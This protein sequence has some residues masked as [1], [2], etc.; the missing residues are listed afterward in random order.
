MVE[1]WKGN[2]IIA[3]QDQALGTN[4]VK[5]HAKLCHNS[6]DGDDSDTD[7]DNDCDDQDYDHED[8]DANNKRLW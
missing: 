5:H 6:N 7:Y 3:L 1:T 8:V 4:V 2:L